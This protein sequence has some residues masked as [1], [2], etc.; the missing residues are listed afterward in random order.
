MTIEIERPTLSVAQLTRK[1]FV[2]SYN[3]GSAGNKSVGATAVSGEIVGVGR[4]QLN[5]LSAEE[6]LLSDEE[7]DALISARLDGLVTAF[8]DGYDWLLDAQVFAYAQVPDVVSGE[9]SDPR[10]IDREWRWV[11]DSR[12]TSDVRT[13]T[14]ALRKACDPGTLQ[15]VALVRLTEIFSGA[16]GDSMIADVV[17]ANPAVEDVELFGQVLLPGTDKDYNLRCNGRL[18]C[19]AVF[20]EVEIP[21]I[22]EPPL[23]E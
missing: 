21:E 20:E 16:A 10:V 13:Y 1:A 8:I 17:A 12:F 22:E 19:E 15:A 23:P 6:L 11:L 9:E 18:R 7:Q 14:A 5:L 3:K 2:E 4:M